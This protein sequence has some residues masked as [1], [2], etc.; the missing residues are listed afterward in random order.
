MV[1]RSP[2][3]T[4]TSSAP[5]TLP[6]GD[7]DRR[8]DRLILAAAQ[9]ISRQGF[10]GASARS[11]A[12]AAGAS[13]S[14]INYNFGNIERLLLLAFDY[15]VHQTA[16]RLE[17]WEREISAL[18]P[19]ADGAARAL[20]HVLTAWTRDD[21]PLA[22][23]YQE[24]LAAGAGQGPAAAWTRLWR[25]F[26]LRAAAMFGLD[27]I[28]GRLM[29]VF[30]ESEALFHLSTWSP[31]LERAAFGEMTDYFAATWLGAPRR[32][33]GGAF[34]LAEKTAG[35]RPHGSVPPAAMRIAEAA[36]EVVEA[37]GL[38]GLTH[39]A[40]ATRAGV[41]T[42]AVTHHF[43]SIEDLVAGAIRG[44]VAALQEDALIVDGAPP[45]LD[46]L[47]TAE[48]LFE[49]TR[50]HVVADQRVSPMLRRRRLFLAAVRRADMAGAG[51]VIRF[52]LGGTVRDALSRVFQI[53]IEAL[54]LPSGML[55]R[56][57]SAVWFA[58]AADDDPRDSREVLVDAIQGRFVKGLVKR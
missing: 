50:F 35:A 21:R 6:P 54:A 37:Q 49:A 18:P 57:L 10:A 55:S 38:G 34:A 41:T 30:F 26:W 8:T 12:T 56:L 45:S 7:E 3:A 5:R 43:R 27:E 29:H 15:G 14:A 33:D 20:D 44:Q 53:P 31:A 51:A 36:A 17:T 42:G 28:Q 24:A 40:V 32:T 2:S 11:V 19:T 58:C 13:P 16:E 4:F 39:R 25:D 48:R 1:I 23:L 52:S 46:E 22:L 9:Q 47:E